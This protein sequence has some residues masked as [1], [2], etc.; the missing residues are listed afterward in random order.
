MAKHDV[1]FSIPQRA[2]GKA[3]VKFQV[4]R[5]GSVHGTLEVSNGSLVWFPKGTTY[6]L[7]MSW[8]K[9]DRIMQDNATRLER[10]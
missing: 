9:F 5:D 3:D 7:K 6:G 8:V 4:K 10:R 1:S 2:L